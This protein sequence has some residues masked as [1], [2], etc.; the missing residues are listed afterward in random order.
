MALTNPKSH[1]ENGDLLSLL[2]SVVAQEATLRAAAVTEGTKNKADK[3]TTLAGYG[4][5]DAY[6]QAETDQ[7]ISD[8]IDGADLSKYVEKKDGFDLVSD[9]NV[10]QIGANKTAIETLNGAETVEGSVKKA[11][12][13]GINDFATKAT[14]DGTINTF[15]ELIDYAASHTAEF[16]ELSGE[17]Q[18]NTTAIGVLNGDDKTVGSVAK[19]VKDAVEASASDLNDAIDAVAEDLATNYTKT[20]DLPKSSVPADMAEIFAALYPTV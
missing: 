19:T 6:T 20:A 18:S 1:V 16:S 3:A 14:E 10:A 7:K 12:A 15:K 2:T 17:V 4:I 8:A 5:V 13:D 9:E 11:V